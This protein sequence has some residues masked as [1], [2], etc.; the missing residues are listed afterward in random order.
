MLNSAGVWGIWQMRRMDLWSDM[1]G[2]GGAI[3]VCS[4]RMVVAGTEMTQS[5]LN[6]GNFMI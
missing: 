6:P 2:M 5:P 3:L 4:S 1:G